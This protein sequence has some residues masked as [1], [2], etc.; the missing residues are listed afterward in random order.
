MKRSDLEVK[1]LKILTDVD[2]QRLRPEQA[3][4]IIDELYVMQS[5]KMKNKQDYSEEQIGV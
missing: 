3:Y 4:R 5:G 2:A 1:V